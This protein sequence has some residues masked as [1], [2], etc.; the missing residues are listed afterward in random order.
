M[1]RKSR[2]TAATEAA[3]N[4]TKRWYAGVYRRLSVEDGDDMEANSITNQ[5]KVCRNHLLTDRTITVE[6]VYTDNGYRR[7]ELRPAGFP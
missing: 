3:C 2:Q 7:N 1:A 5:E 6:K 4:V